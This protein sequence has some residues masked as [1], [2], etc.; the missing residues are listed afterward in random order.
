[1]FVLPPPPL[2]I[3]THEEVH[4]LDNAEYLFHSPRN[5][6]SLTSPTSTA[7]TAI[8]EREGTA[9][10]DKIVLTC[11]QPAVGLPSSPAWCKWMLPRKHCRCFQEEMQA[12]LL[13]QLAA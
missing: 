10:F 8:R 7:H 1:M 12:Q 4:V 6:L 13:A 3:R 9:N 2:C 5:E 11:G